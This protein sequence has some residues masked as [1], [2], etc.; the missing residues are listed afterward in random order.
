MLLSPL[1]IAFDFNRVGRETL[2]ISHGSAVHF[3]S[4]LKFAS[5]DARFSRV[6]GSP[7][8]SPGPDCAAF[9]NEFCF[10]R[11]LNCEGSDLG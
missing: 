2:G 9:N 7:R 3:R 4:S 6:D 1:A 10:H 8:S 5:Q 11:G